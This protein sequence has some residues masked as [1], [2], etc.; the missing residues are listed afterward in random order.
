[1]ACFIG[2][3]F[4][5]SCD[6]EIMQQLPEV[7]FEEG[8][9][10]LT[11]NTGVRIGTELKFKVTVAPNS[12]SESE[13]TGME[14]YITNANGVKVLD[15][16]PAIEDPTDENTFIFTYTPDALS[17]YTVTASVV[18][19]AGK[20]KTDAIVV[21]CFEDVQAGEYGAYCGA[22]NLHG[23]VTSNQIAGYDAYQHEE[24]DIKDVPVTI[25]LGE[26]NGNIIK[27]GLDIDDSYIA[28]EGTME[29][30]TVTLS[31]ID[32]YKSINLFVSVAVHFTT[33]ITGVI[34][35]DVMILSGT[36]EGTGTARV[37]VAKLDVTFEEG[38]VAG[39]LQKMIAK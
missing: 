32:F 22:M 14:F 34:D 36:A 35:D 4:F 16:H 1:M 18:D 29:G 30:N 21:G 5:A 17:T 33:N 24:I 9:G 28:L 27:I 20:T 25:T 26:L 13:L 12:G 10:Y 11:H 31:D 19:Q 2:L 38:T 3:M 6:P 37:I 8:E 39:E 23:Y 7:T 15:E